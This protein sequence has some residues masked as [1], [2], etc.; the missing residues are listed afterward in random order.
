MLTTKKAT[1]TPNCRN[2]R[3]RLILRRRGPMKAGA[4]RSP[5]PK[6]AK[7]HRAFKP[8]RGQT[9][10][11]TRFP[12]LL[13]CPPSKLR[14]LKAPRP[15]SSLKTQKT[16]K[17]SRIPKKAFSARPRWA[18]PWCSAWPW[19]LPC[20]FCCPPSSPTCWWATTTATPLRGT[21]STVS[22]AWRCSLPTSGLSAL[23]PTSSACSLITGPSTK[24]FIALSMGS[25]SRPK[26][27]ASSR[28]CM[29]AAAPRFW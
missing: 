14:P 21:S 26:M 1:P 15:Q 27:R 7:V 12:R 8:K 17:R 6:E 19:A 10:K 29:C 25:S 4:H 13:E 20:S 3:R 23:C 28:A 18:F 2:A 9:L 24:P 16:P 22:C 11:A 5:S